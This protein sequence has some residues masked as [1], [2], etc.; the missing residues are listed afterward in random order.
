MSI[1]SFIILN[2]LR[3]HAIT[4]YCI[5]KVVNF[6]Q[7]ATTYLYWGRAAEPIAEKRHEG[8]VYGRIVSP[9]VFRAWG[10]AAWPSGA[11]RN[12]RPPGKGKPL[13]LCLLSERLLA[14]GSYAHVRFACASK[15]SISNTD[16][17]LPRREAACFVNPGSARHTVR[18]S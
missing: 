10:F 4:V 3:T 6:P 16:R 15:R 17:R 1:Q 9:R 12:K 18:R 13:V 2:M 7:S 5:A 8:G 14:Q 11:Q